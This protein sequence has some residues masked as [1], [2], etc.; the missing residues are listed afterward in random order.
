[1]TYGNGTV[2]NY[3]Y[4]DLERVVGI[5]YNNDTSLSRRYFYNG[6]GSICGVIDTPS[7]RQFLYE[8]DVLGR[9]TNSMQMQGV[10]LLHNW[11]KYDDANRVAERYYR[12][13]PTM[14]NLAGASNIVF[15]NA[16][17]FVYTYDNGDGKLVKMTAPGGNTAAENITFNYAYDAIG[18]ITAVSVSGTVKK[19]DD[20][21]RAVF[22]RDGTCIPI[23]D[24]L[25]VNGEWFAGAD[26]LA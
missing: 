21:E 9:L 7:S 6:E 18:N 5:R 8:Y 17:G 14:V 25:H 10:P 1:M 19:I 3:A 20:F 24:I 4:D 22:L 16:R 2:V 23:D 13:N 12:V 15:D 11:Y 26:Y